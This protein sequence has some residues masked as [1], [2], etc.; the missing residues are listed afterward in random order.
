[1]GGICGGYKESNRGSNNRRR[2]ER[3]RGKG[4]SLKTSRR[5]ERRWDDVCS[6]SGSM[7][8]TSQRGLLK[9][10][11]KKRVPFGH[12]WRHNTVLAGTRDPS[13]AL[14]ARH[15]GGWGFRDPRIEC[16]WLYDWE[17][18]MGC[19]TGV[20]GGHR[21]AAV[22]PEHH[23]AAPRRRSSTW[24][25]FIFSSQRILC[26]RQGTR[27]SWMRWYGLDPSPCAVLGLMHQMTDLGSRF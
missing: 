21:V 27:T 13:W 6:S 24:I 10:M 17:S 3:S 4:N 12:V 23:T 5:G 8:S 16:W 2:A 7:P 1:M 15:F 18:D 25:S 22:C 11:E 14:G 26:C 20:G 19:S 9:R